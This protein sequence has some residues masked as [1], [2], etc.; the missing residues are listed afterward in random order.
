MDEHDSW[1]GD[2]HVQK[3][4]YFLQELLNVPL[5]FKFILYKHG[6]YS[7]DLNDE[8]S[9]LRADEFLDIYVRESQYGPSYCLGNLASKLRQK[10]P[11]T[12]HRFSKQILFVAE[13]IGDK[14]VSELE[15]LATALFVRLNEKE[16][17]NVADAAD[18]LTRYKP[19]VPTTMAVQAITRVDEIRNAVSNRFA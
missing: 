15:R 10:F 8:M 14:G 5:G 3:A 17:L 2:T 18:V 9:A 4:C 12:S 13:T 19:H 16:E 1:C 11:K 6:P 7:F